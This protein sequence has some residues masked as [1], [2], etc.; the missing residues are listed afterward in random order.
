MKLFH[1]TCEETGIMHNSDEIF[2]YLRRFE[3]KTPFE[4]LS[5]WQL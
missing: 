1:R 3:E 4:Q 5:L 2:A